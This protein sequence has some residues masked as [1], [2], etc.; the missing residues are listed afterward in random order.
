MD[1]RG[2]TFAT[3][4]GRSC[5]LQPVEFLHRFLL[6]VLP[7]GFHKLRHYGL[8]STHH[9]AAGT[10]G[11]VCEMLGAL[12]TPKS[13]PEQISGAGEQEIEQA[14]PE[15]WAECLLGLTGIDVRR[16]PRCQRGK[17]LCAPLQ[18]APRIGREDSS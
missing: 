18:T 15:T 12:Q 16:C 5:T 6:H 2:V 1:E 8:C 17:M 4:N 3:K 14:A 13:E 9:I 10:I 7:K 11:K